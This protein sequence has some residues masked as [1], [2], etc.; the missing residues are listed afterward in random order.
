M[1][2][3]LED[4]GVAINDVIDF[5]SLIWWSNTTQGIGRGMNLTNQEN[6]K[7]GGTNKKTPVVSAFYIKETKSLNDFYIPYFLLNLSTR[8]AVSSIF[9]L[10]V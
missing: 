10:P 7:N 2:A 3:I 8:P 6:W 4:D 9:C 1:A 5:Y